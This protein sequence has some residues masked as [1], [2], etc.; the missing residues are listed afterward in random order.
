MKINYPYFGSNLTRTFAD[1]FGDV[2]AFVNDWKA[3]PFSEEGEVDDN[4]VK[5]TYFLLASRYANSTIANLDEDQFKFKLFSLVWQKAP[6][7]AKSKALRN[8]LLDLNLDEILSN[9]KAIY[10]HSY[11]PSTEPST[12]S[13]E[14]LTTINDQNVTINKKGKVVGIAEYLA[15][16]DNDPTEDY[17]RCFKDL[18]IKIVEPQFELLYETDTEEVQDD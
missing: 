15:L 10:N 14:E 18:F 3:L 9:G 16:I 8:T 5:L 12:G 17:I 7:W 6:V 4:A 11:N 2:N 1:V 13:T